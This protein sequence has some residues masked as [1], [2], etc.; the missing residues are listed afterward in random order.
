M[1]MAINSNKHVIVHGP[2]VAM[3]TKNRGSSGEKIVT[4]GQIKVM[5]IL[6]VCVDVY[7]SGLKCWEIFDKLVFDIYQA[8]SVTCVV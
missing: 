5:L 6:A 4:T 1:V 7:A 2:V 8:V 3:S